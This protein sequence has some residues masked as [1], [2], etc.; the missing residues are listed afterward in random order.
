[1]PG[2]SIVVPVYNEEEKLEKVF[3]HLMTTHFDLSV[4]WIFV[5]DCSTDGSLKILRKLQKEFS[6]KNLMILCQDKNRGKGAA[7]RVGFEK[8]TGDAIAV[9]DADFEYDPQDLNRLV[10]YLTTDQADVVYGSRFKR[11]VLQVHRT[12]HYFTNRLLT[13][14]SNLFSGIYLTDMETCYKVFRAD[15]L[16]S[17][18]LRSNRF[19]FEVE[20][21]AYL[22]KI[23]PRILE[24]PISYY[25]RT[26]LQ[27][28]KIT[29]RDGVAA[30]FHIV[31]FNGLCSQR[32]AF[33]DKLPQK[34]LE[35]RPLPSLEDEPKRMRRVKAR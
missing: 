32:S 23:R 30:L 28:K 1:M 21:T 26:K 10:S 16:K 13:L 29:W 34:Y 31:R 2:L 7:L 8:A 14:L 20:V 24:I 33:K 4:E 3:R 18:N 17:M 12:Y 15:L 6:K 22:A 35:N 19:G 11:S 25:P 27:G 5:D 9:Q